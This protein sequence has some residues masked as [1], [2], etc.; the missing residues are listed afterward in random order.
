MK[1]WPL[2]KAYFWETAPF[3][4]LLLPLL[5]GIWLYPD[6]HREGFAS[7]IIAG[8][9]AA[10]I[11][12]WAISFVKG[13]GEVIR[14]IAFACLNVSLFFAA[15][16]VCY[17]HDIRNDPRWMGHSLPAADGYVVRLCKAPAEKERTWKLEVDVTHSVTGDKVVQAKGKAFV[18]MNKYKAPALREGDVIVVPNKWQC[19]ENRGNPFEIDYAGYAARDNIHHL[20]FISGKEI[21]IH[22]YADE[23][24][25]PWIRKVHHWCVRQLEWYITDRATLGLLKAMLFDDRDMLDGELTEAYSETGIVHIIAISGGHITIFFVL[26]A[27]LLGWIKHRKYHWVKYIAAIPLVWI[28]VVVAGA[29]PSAVRAALMFS[30]LGIGFAL[31]KTPNGINQLLA[32]AFILLCANPMWLYS[33]GFQLSFVAVLSIMLFYTP[34]YKWIAPVNKLVRLLWSAVAVSI[35]VEILVAP[36]VIYYFHLFP[37]QFIVANVL[38]YFFMGVVLVLGMVL[39]AVSSFYPIAQFIATVTAALATS[40]NQ[41]VYVLQHV[42][43]ESFHRLTLTGWQ[44]V[45]VYSAIAGLAIFFLKKNKAAFFAGVIA[46]VLFAVSCCM[47][48]WRVLRQ[49]M[50]VVYNAGKDSRIELVKGR[51]AVILYGKDSVS[52]ATEKFVLEP[53]HINLHISTVQKPGKKYDM[54]HIGGKTVF[55]LDKPIG[56]TLLPADYV[57]LVGNSADVAGIKKVFN[58]RLL[59]IA[60]TYSRQKA[61]TI[62][63]TAEMAGL[64]VH[65]V[66][67]DRAF[68]L[69]KQ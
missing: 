31:Q 41:L 30:V 58:P 68:V 8:V 20:Q 38:A 22:R 12:F 5:A 62:I 35:A 48:Q 7:W 46:L 61:A 50:F 59:V 14:F 27:F 16:A 9:V 53:A 57:V 49:E 15:W 10:F 26:I 64:Q 25:L 56:D 42:N 23:H 65:D 29:P 3:F 60:G 44:L 2:N 34:V 55:I 11:A 43:L 24:S 1:R 4:R 6:A 21:V 36:L 28:Y 52:E 69:T 66:R 33:I 47:V 63:K 18:Y 54:V 37:L 32:T 17:Y 13:R 67:G 45:W 40:F 39:I 51:K 19:I